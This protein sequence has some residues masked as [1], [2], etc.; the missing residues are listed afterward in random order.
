MSNV[1]MFSRSRTIAAM[2]L[3]L[4][5]SGIAPAQDAAPVQ[6]AAPAAKPFPMW[7]DPDFQSIAGMLSGTWK[8]TPVARADDAGKSQDIHLGI[9]PVVV[10]GFADTLY[11]E[12]APANALF[13]PY[14]QSVWQLYKKG[15]KVHLRTLQ[16]RRASGEMPSAVGC[17]A[18]PDAFPLELTK[19]D[20]IGTLDL[21]LAVDAGNIR[22]K[23]THP[24]PTA[25]AGAVE[26]TS[27]MLVT[28][29]RLETIDRGFAADGKVVWGS[30]EGQKYTY[31]RYTPAIEVRREASGVVIVDFKQPTS[32]DTAADGYRVAAHYIGSVG[33]GFVFDSTRE[34]N[35]VFTY[36]VGNNLIAGFVEGMKGVK[37]GDRRR[38]YI[39]WDQAYGDKGNPRGRI[40]PRANLY[41]DIEI[42]AVDA[43]APPPPMPDGQPKPADGLTVS[44]AGNAAPSQPNTQP[45]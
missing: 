37:K 9:A 29:D 38:L 34:S 44:P 31:E 18:I 40:P 43:P 24:Y 10:T 36:N 13:S 2:A 19:K 27:E 41:Y 11:V 16:F 32:G 30:G 25:I 21:E 15:G 17:W 3:V 22:A 45:K 4:G 35:R 7:T 6:P 26:M 39:P 28:P 42:L 5:L 1:K 23:T 12:A 8:S 14:Q 20:F 33:N